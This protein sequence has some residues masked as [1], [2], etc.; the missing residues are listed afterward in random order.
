MVE[1]DSLIGS[2][3][4][5]ESDRVREAPPLEIAPFR[6]WAPMCRLSTAVD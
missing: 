6:P 5:T 4:T 1:I 2:V 3:S